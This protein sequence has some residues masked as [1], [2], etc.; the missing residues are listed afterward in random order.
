MVEDDPNAYSSDGAV[1]SQLEV[2]SKPHHMT[3]PRVC[4]L[5]VRIHVVHTRLYKF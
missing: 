4:R 3:V 1:S 2:L 5:H